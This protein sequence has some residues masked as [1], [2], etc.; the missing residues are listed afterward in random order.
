MA[1]QHVRA[2]ACCE[3][4]TW[5]SAQAASCS[6]CRLIQAFLEDLGGPVFDGRASIW[7][8]HEYQ[9]LDRLHEAEGGTACLCQ[10]SSTDH[11]RPWRGC[12]QHPQLAGSTFSGLAVV[13][14]HRFNVRV[15]RSASKVLPL[16]V[17][18]QVGERS[19]VRCSS[20]LGRRSFLWAVNFGSVVHLTGCATWF[21]QPS[22]MGLSSHGPPHALS[23]RIRC[24]VGHLLV[25][26]RV[27]ALVAI[28]MSRGC[29]VASHVTLCE[30]WQI[31]LRLQ[32]FWTA[33]FRLRLWAVLAPRWRSAARF[34]TGRQVKIRRAGQ[35]YCLVESLRFPLFCAFI[36][37][38]VAW[39]LLVAAI[40]VFSL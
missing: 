27:W 26:L 22:G 7:S 6:Q 33:L 12:L 10:L 9:I 11:R 32:S 8:C 31:L 20:E 5:I 25:S 28:F 13:A 19:R 14:D 21:L 16:C 38:L 39:G 24:P 23:L 3:C 29:R 1:S 34:R 2:N 40:I 36:Q 17:S 35:P 37:A 4:S 30:T 18:A 15:P